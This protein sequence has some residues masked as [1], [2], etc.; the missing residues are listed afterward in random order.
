VAT[1]P[2]AQAYSINLND[3][4]PI[5][6][7]WR[8][9]FKP[10]RVSSVCKRAV[11]V[12]KYPVDTVISVAC[13]R[14]NINIGF[15][16]EI[17]KEETNPMPEKLRSNGAFIRAS[18]FLCFLSFACV[19]NSSTQDSS[20]Y[21][22]PGNLVVSRSVYDNNPD[23]V[24]VGMTLPPKCTNSCA[25]AIV[26]GTYP[27]V[28][29][30]ASVDGSFGITSK[31]FLDDITTDGTL[32]NSLEV[33]NSSQNAVP[34]TKDQMVTSFSSKSELALNLSTDGNYLTF[35][36]YLAPIDAIDVSNSNT[37]GV[38]DPSNPVGGSFFRVVAQIDGKGKL[39]YT[40]TNAYSGN[41]GRAAILNN[42]SGANVAYTSGNAGNG[43]TPQPDGII[44]GA[45]A[46]ILAPEVKALVAQR[47]GMPTPVGSFNIM[48]LGDPADKIGKDTN[49]RGLAIFDNVLYY[50][51]GSGGNGVNTVYFVDPTGTVC[52]DTNGTGLPAPGATLPL[53]PLTYNPDPAVI[54]ADGLV[55]NNMCI[56]NG[57]P[58][59]LKS[60]TSFPFGIWFANATTLYVADE[61]NG[62]VGSTVETFYDPAAAQTTAG[63]QKWILVSGKWTFA[64]TL[65]A[66]L[67]L[68]VPYTVQGYPT[69]NNSGTGGTGFPWTPA[70]DGLRNITGRLNRDGTAT[71]YA[72][73]STVS[74]SGDQGADP[75]KLVVII[76]DVS[77][78]GPT[79]PTGERFRTLRTA[80]Y[81]EVL[82]GVSFTP[83]NTRD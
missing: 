64:Y 23:N 45:G 58:T 38:V 76:D 83:G 34:P 9:T 61:G 72:I 28:F 3:H 36:G 14:R 53:S 29:N 67:N 21:L 24:Q 40:K 47:P 49:F 80:G 51:K 52:T 48:Q 7:F 5:R 50:T 10:I 69:G 75:N 54:Q 82:R 73:T 60:K 74:G 55:P 65:N 16:P 31:I 4:R 33:P 57:F 79:A 26:D 46:Q 62:T 12:L 59:A 35:M 81:G 44:I 13:A 6:I 39:H 37:P 63:L 68:G 77:A 42:T 32:I 19:C 20:A 71:I 2:Q 25:Q 8:H 30:N 43:S 18:K 22:R 27:F 11:T 41:N 17:P 56:L 70:T 78:V 1:E 66:G 15:T